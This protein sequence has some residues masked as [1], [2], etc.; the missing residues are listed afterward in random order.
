[1]FDVLCE[2]LYFRAGTNNGL[3]KNNLKNVLRATV[4]EIINVHGLNV[5]EIQS[6]DEVKEIHLFIADYAFYKF[7]N[8]DEAGK[9]P[10]H[11]LRRLR[12]LHVNNTRRKI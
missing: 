1:M 6:L 9:V 2:L 5:P 7:K 12:N 10:E 3:I 4:D 11:L 8:R